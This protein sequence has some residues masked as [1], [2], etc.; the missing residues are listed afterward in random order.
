MVHF[1]LWMGNHVLF[2]LREAGPVL[3]GKGFYFPKQVFPKKAHRY[4]SYL[5]K[6][7]HIPAQLKGR[8]EIPSS[9]E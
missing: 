2:L 7:F 4:F 5:E 8:S 6:N 9:K 3:S 1:F